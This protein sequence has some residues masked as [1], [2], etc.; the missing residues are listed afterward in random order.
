M[1]NEQRAVARRMLARFP[2]L[3][4]TVGND[5]GAETL[6]LYEKADVFN[7]AET[8]TVRDETPADVLE[9]DLNIIA[10]NFSE[11]LGV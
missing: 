7:R 8:L 6:T 10:V 1:T 2:L 9:R 4:V 5:N 3:D 11:S